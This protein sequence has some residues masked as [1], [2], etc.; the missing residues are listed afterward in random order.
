MVAHHQGEVQ[1]VRFTAV[2]QRIHT[3]VYCRPFD[4]AILGAVGSLTHKGIVRLGTGGLG[5]AIGIKKS[6]VVLGLAGYG[7]V[8]IDIGDVVAR[9]VPYAAGRSPG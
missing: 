1:G 6:S 7:E 8:V 2:R 4:T 3:E 9:L 5:T